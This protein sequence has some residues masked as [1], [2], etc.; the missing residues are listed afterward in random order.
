MTCIDFHRNLRD[1]PFGLQGAICV[2]EFAAKPKKTRSF[3][4]AAGVNYIKANEFSL[5]WLALFWRDKSHGINTGTF[6]SM[7]LEGHARKW[8]SFSV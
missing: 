6:V 3:I 1:P 5:Q 4:R 7:S 8:S 2:G